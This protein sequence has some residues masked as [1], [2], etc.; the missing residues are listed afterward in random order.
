MSRRYKSKKFIYKPRHEAILIFL[1][2][3]LSFLSQTN[4]NLALPKFVPHFCKLILALT[5]SEDVLKEETLD[6]QLLFSMLVLSEIIKCD[7]AEL[8]PYADMLIKV[9]DRTLHLTSRKGY[10]L[11]S[12][13][14]KH[15]L[16]ALT[17]INALDFRSISKPWEA[18]KD[19]EKELPI[20]VNID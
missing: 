10:A 15:L 6:D 18:Y 9:L 12:N 11:S 7:G 13:L 20:R 14:L 5:E 17:L 2:V 1:F 3:R 19:V 4:P 8:L 16:K